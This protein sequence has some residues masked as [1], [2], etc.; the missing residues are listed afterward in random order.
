MTGTVRNL[1]RY[2]VALPMLTWGTVQLRLDGTCAETRFRLSAERTSPCDSAGV[3]VQSTTGNR[4][5]RV[6]WWHLNCAGE[7]MLRGLVRHAGY[8]L[9]SPVAPSFPL[10]RVAVCHHISIALYLRIHNA[11]AAA[12]CTSV[13]FTTFSA[14]SLETQLHSLS[15]GPTASSVNP[16]SVIHAARITAF[17]FPDL[18]DWNVPWANTRQ[19]HLGG[20]N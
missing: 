8:P 6:S 13:E 12:T 17:L 19:N 16:R 2:T 10:P 4:G 1:S 18:S 20:S 9:H 7:A 3:T 14:S 5:V 11:T 15:P